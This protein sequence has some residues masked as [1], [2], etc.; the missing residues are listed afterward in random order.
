MEDIPLDVGQNMFFQH[1]GCP[2]YYA[3]AVHQYLDATFHDRWIGRGSLFTWPPR[4]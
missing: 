2:A 1:D 3:L 4:Q